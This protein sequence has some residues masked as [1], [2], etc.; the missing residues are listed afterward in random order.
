MRLYHGTDMKFR[1]PKLEKCNPYTDFGKGFYLTHELER[2]KEWGANHNPCEY[3]VNMYEVADDYIQEAKRQGFK[4][5]QFSKATAGWARFVYRN[6]YDETFV[7]EYDIVVGPVADNALQVQ[8]AKMFRNKLSFEDIA[9][10][11]KYEKF[12]KPQICF[13]SERSLNL[14]KYIEANAYSN[15]TSCKHSRG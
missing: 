1:L 6:R 12:K 9:P 8:F 11:I 14:L 10:T 2:A 4:V 7:H 13:C 15:R 5:L 3:R